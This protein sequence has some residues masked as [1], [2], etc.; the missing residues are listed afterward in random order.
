MASEQMMKML[1]K[2]NGKIDGQDEKL[3]TQLQKFDAFQQA[4]DEVKSEINVMKASNAE[5][6]DE[7]MKLKEM[8]FKHE[9]RFEEGGGG[10]SEDSSGDTRSKRPCVWGNR[11]ENSSSNSQFGKYESK[12]TN[13]NYDVIKTIMDKRLFITNFVGNSSRETRIKFV[14]DFLE[15]LGDLSKYGKLVPFCKDEEGGEAYI[16]F[17]S[18]QMVK[19]FIGEHFEKIKE[20]KVSGVHGE[21]DERKIRMDANLEKHERHQM[22][23]TKNLCNAIKEQSSIDHADIFFQGKAG[24][25]KFRKFK[26]VF[27]R[28]NKEGVISVNI[29]KQ[30]A[31]DSK[32]M[33]LEDTLQP[34]VSKFVA[35]YQ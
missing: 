17:E 19:S 8:V 21:D 15:D 16:N 7:M 6:K 33:G 5:M 14:E 9:Q 35:S 23:A 2:I 18:K 20:L 34:I 4:F 1:E 13:D 26:V 25:I 31:K 28:V 11:N 24:I 30:N 27:V 22:S 10:N 29:N 12:H 3:N 32:I